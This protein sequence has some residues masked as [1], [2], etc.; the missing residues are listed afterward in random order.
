MPAKPSN[1]R[2]ATA[3]KWRRTKIIATLGPS[4]NTR[5][6][7]DKLIAAG[8]DVVRINMSHGDHATH[9]KTIRQVRLASASAGRHVGV[10]MDLCGP[11]IRVGS[12]ENGAIHLSTG[13]RVVV[14][15]RKCLGRDGLIPSQYRLLH[16]DVAAGQHILLDDGRLCLRVVELDGRD[17]HC[18]VIHG[19]RLSDR[20]GMNLPDSA[21]STP[22]VTAKD[23]E[24]AAF[25]VEMEVDFIALSF[26]RS[27]QD[28]RRLRRYLHKLGA[29]VPLIAKIERPEA[30]DGIDSVL[31]VSDGIMV[32]RGDLGIELPAER[33]P[34]IQRDLIERARSAGLPVIVATQMLES[35]ME[36]PRPTRAE[37]T[38][39]A[40]A[41][42]LSADA[43]MLSGETAAGKYPLEAV[44]IMDRVLREVEQRQWRDGQFAAQ[45]A[46]DRTSRAHLLRES[47]AHAAVQL[48]ADLALD[49]IIVP[50]DTGTTARIVA[51]RRPLAPTLGVCS[52]DSV[53]RRMT[54]HWGIVPFRVEHTEATQWRN[55]CELLAGKCELARGGGNVLLVS[56]FNDDPLLNEP[57]LK[58]LS[59]HKPA[60]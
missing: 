5:A 50:T 19:G 49:A 26:V 40:G 48:A 1:H 38:D 16:K 55:L 32:A 60:R 9:R 22:T 27:A 3:F 24:D 46:V 35:M 53:C 17:V 7:I 21:L 18:R 52:S 57:V 15:T 41:A 4:S 25:G 13:D 51:A 12:F 10:L 39:V 8:V 43:A 11:K 36:H 56:G 23:R 29:M 20:K 28:I 45:P 58:L 44:L 31:A 30:V 6:M 37:V 2:C 34:L 59:L 14:T 33:V 42:L 54:L 47:M